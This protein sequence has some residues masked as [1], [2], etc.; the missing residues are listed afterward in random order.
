MHG[1]VS[2]D[3]ETHKTRTLGCEK[4]NKTKKCTYVNCAT[5]MGCRWTSLLIIAIHCKGALCPT[6]KCVIACCDDPEQSQ[7][8]WVFLCIWMNHGIDVIQQMEIILWKSGRPCHINSI[9]YFKAY[10]ICSISVWPQY[11]IVSIPCSHYL[12]PLINACC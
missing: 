10:C 12:L 6:P 3:C 5:C 11:D 7:M 1:D 4:Q 9:I 8:L 2:S